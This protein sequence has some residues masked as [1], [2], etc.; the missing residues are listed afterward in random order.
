M[1]CP[2]CGG[3]GHIGDACMADMCPMC[4]G[5]GKVTGTCEAEDDPDGAL[6]RGCDRPVDPAD[7]EA[8][9]VSEE[10]ESEGGIDHE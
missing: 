1:I 9:I 2:K 10:M 4:D 8:A 5:D 6:W 3:L 7:V